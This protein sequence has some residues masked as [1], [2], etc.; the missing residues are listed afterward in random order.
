MIWGYF[1]QSRADTFSQTRQVLISIVW[2]KWSG[3][4]QISIAKAGACHCNQ[5]T[6]KFTYNRN[7][8]GIYMY[9]SFL[10]EMLDYLR[11]VL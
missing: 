1:Y 5:I 3:F 9:S 4:L 7:R 11:G 6:Q 2:K 8:K 10:A